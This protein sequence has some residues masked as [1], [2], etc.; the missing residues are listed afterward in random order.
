MVALRNILVPVDFNEASQHA[1]AYAKELARASGAQLHLLHVVDDVFA[2][3]A[4]TEGAL[5]AFPRLARQAEDE[6]RE[7]LKAFV[8][9]RLPDTVMA[10]EVGTPAPAILAYAERIQP[11][12]IVMGTHGLSPKPLG[13]IGSVAAQ[14]V[15]TAECPVVTM[16]KQPRESLVLAPTA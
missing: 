10:V 12:L 7:R 11:G 4:G 9:D 2:L 6:A 16:R 15:R 1:V 3:P 8:T 13:D 5:S 14:V